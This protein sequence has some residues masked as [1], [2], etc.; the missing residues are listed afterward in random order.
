MSPCEQVTEDLAAIVDGDRDAIARHAEHLTSCDACRDARHEAQQ[1]A[2]HVST[3]GADYV[4]GGGLLDRLMVLVDQQKPAPAIVTPAPVVETARAPAKRRPWMAIGAGVAAL[5]ATGTIYI[6]THRAASTQPIV[7][8]R[9]DGPIGKLAQV[10][11]AAA[12]KVDGVMVRVGQGAWSPMHALASIPAGAELRTDERTRA[13]FDLADGTHVVLDHATTLAFDAAEARRMTLVSGRIVADVAHVETRHALLRTPNGEIQIVGTRFEATVAPELTSV[14]VVR[15]MVV[16]TDKTG[17]HE[18][19]RAGEEGMIDHGALSVS[20]TIGLANDVAWS[21]LAVPAADEGLAGLGA[22]RAYKPGESRDRDWKLALAKHDVKVRISGPIARTEI[23]EVFR[24]D[25]PTQLE[26]VYQFPLPADAQID[27]LALDVDNKFVDGAFVDKDRAGKIWKGVIDRAR[28]IQIARPEEIVWVP[29]PWRD[30]ALLDWKRGGKFE[31]K[32]FPIPANGQRTIKIAYTQVVT[33]RGPW[34]QYVYPLPH[35]SDGST[36]ADAMSVDVEV[37]GATPNLVRASNYALVVDPSANVGVNKLAFSQGGFVPRGDLVIDYKPDTAAELRAWTFVG[38]AAVAPDAKLATKKGVGIDPKIVDEQTRVAGDAR[39]TAVLAL[40]PKLPRWTEAKPRDYAIVIDDSQS[41]VGERFKHASELAAQLVAQMDRRDRFTT[42]LCDSEC[43]SYG[44]LRA[45]SASTSSELGAWLTGQRL[46]G[47]SDLVTSVRTAAAV[48]TDVQ[49]EKWVIYVGDGFA[50]TGFRK[51]ADVEHALAEGNSDIHVTTIGIGTDSDET[52]LTAAARGGGG[53]YLA[54]LPGMTATSTAVAALETTY[55]AT[56]RDATIELPAGLADS[57]PTV[58]PS[59]RNGQEVLLSARLTNDV[60]GDVV[61]KGTLAGQPWE[62]RYPIKL[63][64]AAGPANGFVPR[65]W[66]SLAIGELERAGKGEDHVKEI[67]LSQAY[68]VMS[69]ETSLLVLESQA[70][71]DAFGVDRHRPTVQWTGEDAVDEVTSTGA[72]ALATKD[73]MS[74]PS[75]TM[76]IADKAPAPMTTAPVAKKSSFNGIDLGG[77]SAGGDAGSSRASVTQPRD[78]GMGRGRNMIAMRKVW[79]RSAAL[80]SY[81]GVAPELT[82][83]IAASEDALAKAPDSREK[84]R[85]L[86]QALSYAGD[87]SHAKEIAARWLERDRLDPQALGYLADLAGRD[88]ERDESLRTLAGLV[89]LDPDK[90]ALHERM[91]NAYE[92]TGRLAQACGHR[93]ALAT[94]QHTIATAATAARCLRTVGREKDAALVMGEL[95]SD[96]QRGDAERRATVA[97]VEPKLGGDLVING[98]WDRG[99]DLDLTLVAPDGTRVSWQGGRSDVAVNDATALDREE[100]AVKTLRRGNYLVEITRGDA[101]RSAVRGTL[102]ITVLGVKKS[103]PFELTGT[104]ATVGRIDVSLVSH[105][106]AIEGGVAPPQ[107]MRVVIVTAP[108]GATGQRLRSRIGVFRSCYQR[109]LFSDPTATGRVTLTLSTDSTSGLPTV[110]GASSSGH[111][112][113]QVEQCVQQLVS[114]IRVP[115]D[116]GTFAV[117]IDFSPN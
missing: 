72:V 36:V 84:H 20:P 51:A 112:M 74:D 65:L 6:A 99:A 52:V 17:A 73:T 56:L 116:A 11:R 66:A 78:L 109:Q 43:K 103:L 19:V 70:M 27:G 30:P 25:S 9:H 32:I 106:E 61:L 108:S 86:V 97:P 71:F 3:A 95:A 47:A 101:A 39:P 26:G 85:A 114:Q 46:A 48:L 102:D 10:T 117:S 8:V 42:F 12:D 33:P 13:A 80:A 14:Q 81:T 63:A 5:A 91:V 98:T 105:L 94:L 15:G 16:L 40:Q 64:A 83:E 34:R 35:S 111:G 2:K 115:T 96:A 1:I 68:G 104:H 58:L 37:R 22:L 113:T 18:E 76:P 59:I 93:I 87:L 4:A 7:D 23:T 41:M 55:G 67:A 28:P 60:T 21:E 90:V 89:D 88:G 92:R 100:L 82:K 50:T 44:A 31:L 110:K 29:G 62:Q 24:N 49:R 38:G 54:W 79:T 53:S 107:G 69:R 57:A 45:P 75:S 77:E